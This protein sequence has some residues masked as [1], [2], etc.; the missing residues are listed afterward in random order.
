[1]SDVA[2][3][4]LL[5]LLVFFACFLGLW[6]VPPLQERLPLLLLVAATLS[7]VVSLV[8][9]NGPREAMSARIADRIGERVER[10]HS[11]HGLGADEEA[12]EADQA[13]DGRGYR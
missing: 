9:L 12:E 7:M 4:S 13:S 5:R 11:E 10:K 8:F 2:R 3:Y 1:M 6:F